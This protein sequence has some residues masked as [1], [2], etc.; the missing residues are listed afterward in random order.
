MQVRVNLMGGLKDKTPEGNVL[1]VPDGAGIEAVL[2]Q[3]DIDPVQVQIVMVNNK[4][5]PDRSKPLNPDDELTV[6]APV[7]GG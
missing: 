2:K 6:L 7:G 5:Q 1:K 3:L 4:P